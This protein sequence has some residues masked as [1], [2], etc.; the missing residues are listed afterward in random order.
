MAGEE[1]SLV[2]ETSIP[3]N[4]NR[5]RYQRAKLLTSQYRCHAYV[6]GTI[7]SEVEPRFASTHVFPQT[8]VIRPLFLPWVLLLMMK[9][10]IFGRNPIERLHTS[11]HSVAIITGVILQQ[12]G[13]LWTQDLW[14]DPY[15]PVQLQRKDS[16][17]ISRLGIKYNEILYYLVRGRI[18]NSDLIILGLHDGILDEMNI[19]TKNVCSVS[20]GYSTVDPGSDCTLSGPSITYVGEIMTQRHIPELIES[21][22]IV[23]KDFPDIQLNLIGPFGDDREEI[24]T[25]IDSIGVNDNVRITGKIEHSEALKYITGSNIGVSLLSDDVRNYRYSYPIKTLEYMALGTPVIATETPATREL[26][27]SNGVLLSRNTPEEIAAGI[28]EVLCDERH[29]DGDWEIEVEGYR[30]SS[31]NQRI[32]DHLSKLDGGPR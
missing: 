2:W 20:N 21:L 30:W 18:E 5:A 27:E 22:G 4:Q 11:P 12:F 17:L 31:I 10:R 3:S 28:R 7:A 23:V 25:L 29:A 16:D 9:H 24:E 8:R 19:Q 1:L 26:I 32:A 6:V 14:D 13:V 15:L